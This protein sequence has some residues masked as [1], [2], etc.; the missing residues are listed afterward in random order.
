VSVIRTS[1]YTATATAA[2][3]DHD[4]DV[5]QQHNNNCDPAYAPSSSTILKRYLF[6]DCCEVLGRICQDQKQVLGPKLAGVFLCSGGDNKNNNVNAS[7]V[8]G[9][10]GLPSLMYSLSAVGAESLKVVCAPGGGNSKHIELVRNVVLGPRKI[11]PKI[12]ICELPAPA[13]VPITPAAPNNQSSSRK[14]RR[15]NNADITHAAS[16]PHQHQPWWNVHEDEFITIQAT[17]SYATAICTSTSVDSD[18]GRIAVATSVK[19]LHSQE[20]ALELDAGEKAEAAATN[21][22]LSLEETE[23]VGEEE[24]ES[25]SSSSSTTSSSC[26]SSDDSDETEASIGNTSNKPALALSRS[27][28]LQSM[29]T[30]QHLNIDIAYVITLK[31]RDGAQQTRQ[32]QQRFLVAPHGMP[33]HSAS[34]PVPA[35]TTMTRSLKFDIRLAASGGPIM[36]TDN[37]NDASLLSHHSLKIGGQAQKM[38]PDSGLVDNIVWDQGT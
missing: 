23:T 14:R 7:S 31:G 34:L 8:E 15:G 5:E 38:M 3:D 30:Q 16:T 28:S 22:V 6:G 2:E 32:L 12:Q 18:S 20:K 35:E 9:M 27:P 1:A 24:S 17:A 10:A 11:H 21:K 25:P 36:T 29:S 26:S 37:D 33:I 13:P 19:E 4:D